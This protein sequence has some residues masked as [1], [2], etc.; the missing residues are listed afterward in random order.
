VF[1]TWIVVLPR[2]VFCLTTVPRDCGDRKIPLV[3]PVTEFSSISLPLAAPT[4]PIPKSSAG[5]A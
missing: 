2:T 5:S 1:P 3:L 4:T